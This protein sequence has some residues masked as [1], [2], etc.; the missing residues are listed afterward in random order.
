MKTRRH[1]IRDLTLSTAAVDLM[2]RALGSESKPADERIASNIEAIQTWNVGQ[3]ILCVDASFCS[4]ALK[5]CDFLPV[6][7]RAYTIRAVRVDSYAH[8]TAF[9]LEEIVNNRLIYGREPG[10][11]ADRF[12][13]LEKTQK[14]G[15]VEELKEKYKAR[16]ARA[17]LELKDDEK[18]TWGQ[19]Y[20]QSDLL[21]FSKWAYRV[22]KGWY[23]FSLGRIPPVWTD[24]LDD[25]LSWLESQCPDF[26]IHQ[27]K[28][29]GRGLRI[30]LGTKTDFVIP[31]ENIRSEIFKLQDLLITPQ[32][33]HEENL[34]TDAV[35]TLKPRDDG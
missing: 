13:P 29:K 32:S 4:E 23:G 18:R 9:L 24:I 17:H 16:L 33:V 26:E 20:C 19:Y 34:T 25:F 35:D 3:K 22:G 31:D 2:P 28:I 6:A 30:Y 21:L 7:N 5:I 12:Q 8:R 11:W 14:T 15:I 27:V 1:F 10:F